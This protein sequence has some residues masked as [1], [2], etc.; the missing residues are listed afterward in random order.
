[1]RTSSKLMFS[2]AIDSIKTLIEASL[3]SWYGVFRTNGTTKW[4]PST[5]TCSIPRTENSS[6]WNRILSLRCVFVCRSGS[7]S[8]LAF[9]D[10]GRFVN[11]IR[12]FELILIAL[13]NGNRINSQNDDGNSSNSIHCECAAINDWVNSAPYTIKRRKK[14]R[15]KRKATALAGERVGG[16]IYDN[17][18]N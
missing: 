16:V 10:V 15:A 12:Y 11:V 4:V 14:V 18:K 3:S 6:N 8:L 2:T 7:C 1:M 13:T 5:E 9:D 17:G